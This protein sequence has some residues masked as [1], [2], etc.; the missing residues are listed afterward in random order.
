LPPALA[1]L[2]AASAHRLDAARRLRLETVPC[3]VVEDDDLRA[4]LV[5][6]DENLMRAELGPAQRAKYTARRKAI[7]VELHPEAG[8]GSP[9]VSRQVGDTRERADVERFT[10][11][12]AASTG[13]SERAI[14]RDAHSCAIGG[15]A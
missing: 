12:T 13:R 4:E 11:D 3:I 14:Q 15:K 5:M 2:A 7:Y 10:A 9:G 1:L 6:I 8:H